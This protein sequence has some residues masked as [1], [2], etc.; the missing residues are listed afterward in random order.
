MSN[1]Y[2]GS[3]HTDILSI[4]VLRE[5]FWLVQAGKTIF[6]HLITYE[7]KKISLKLAKMTFYV[8]ILAMFKFTVILPV[9]AHMGIVLGPLGTYKIILKSQKFSQS[10]F[11]FTT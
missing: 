10:W 9:A 7:L 6:Y 4:L 11:N 5:P 8:V 1:A 3:H 2:N